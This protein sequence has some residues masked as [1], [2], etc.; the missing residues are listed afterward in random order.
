MDKDSFQATIGLVSEGFGVCFVLLW[1]I[2]LVLGH[3]RTLLYIYNQN[4]L[5]KAL[6]SS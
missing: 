4:M 5:E 1:C 2:F 6:K 3:V